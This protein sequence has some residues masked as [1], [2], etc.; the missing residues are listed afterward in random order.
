MGRIRLPSG[1]LAG[2]LALSP[3]GRILY[4]AASARDGRSPVI[5]YSAASGRMLAANTRNVAA[6]SLGGGKVTAAPGGVWV[7]YRT[8]MAGQTVLLQQEDLRMVKLPGLNTPGGLFTW[9]M[10][11]GTEYAGRSVFLARLD[12][13]AVCLNPSTGHV[14]ARGTIGTNAEITGL[15]GSGSAGNVLYLQASAGVIAVT[16]PA[17]CRA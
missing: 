14:R 5:E 10:W 2:D 15:L 11:A 13:I 4:L 3:S 12:R 6:V 8:G 1:L 16:P 17:A 7:S 9:T